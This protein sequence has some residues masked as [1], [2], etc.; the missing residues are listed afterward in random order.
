ME[1]LLAEQNQSITYN[2][3]TNEKVIKEV[4]TKTIE[5]E[6]TIKHLLQERETTY[7]DGSKDK[8]RQ[9]STHTGFT[10]DRDDL[11]ESY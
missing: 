9:Y 4:V 11:T 8:A 5:L 10:L 1:P 3:S 7:A 2:T 6:V